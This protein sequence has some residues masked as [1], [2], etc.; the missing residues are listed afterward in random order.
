MG[1]ARSPPCFAPQGGGERQARGADLEARGAQGATVPAQEG[2]LW[3]ND[4]SCVRL[5]WH[6]I[7]EW[8]HSGRKSWVAVP[9]D[10]L[11]EGAGS[12]HLMF[13][14]VFPG[15]Q[16]RLPS[17]KERPCSRAF[18]LD[19][20]LSVC[21]SFRWAAFC[22]RGDKLL[23]CCEPGDAGHSTGLPQALSPSRRHPFQAVLT[24]D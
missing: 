5:R 21:R 16:C 2:R 12:A 20:G 11:W 14:K 10:V 18:H 7:S 9:D 15:F 13:Q 23:C 22:R 8:R 24:S 17:H 1:P 4:G 6:D 3:L 19:P